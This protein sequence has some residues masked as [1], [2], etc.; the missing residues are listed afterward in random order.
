MGDTALGQHKPGSSDAREMGCT[1][2]V[3]DNHYGA[4][5]HGDGTQYG[6]FVSSACELHR[7][8]AI[9]ALLRAVGGD[10]G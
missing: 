5:R 6:W 1:C 4:G 2:P 8:P 10:N 9:A 7:L 3:T